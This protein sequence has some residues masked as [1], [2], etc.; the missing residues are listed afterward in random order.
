MTPRF[1]VAFALFATFLT[2]AV[3][4][5]APPTFSQRAPSLKPTTTSKSM[6]LGEVSDFYSTYP[7]QS[8]ILTCGVKASIADCIAQVRAW[9][10]SGDPNVIEM[11]R[12]AAYIVYGG[13]FI[14]MMSHLE[15]NHLFPLMF[16]DDHSIKTIVSKVIF[17]DFV[18]API[19]W[20]PPAYI[21]KALLYEYPVEEGL[22]KYWND[23]CNEDLL[24]KYWTVW[25]PAQS[26]SFSVVPDH[27]RVAFMA[28]IS[29]FWFIIF[30]SLSSKKN[31]DPESVS[32]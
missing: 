4:F 20:L 24:L 26:I 14:G 30:S 8:A 13:I 3:A 7:L 31:T 17:D 23:I 9:K 15:Y 12:N 19:M 18:S 28:S 21:I 27:L 11:R 25:V 16:G 1:V 22:K 32:E 6:G 10:N 5:Q 2:S 29:F